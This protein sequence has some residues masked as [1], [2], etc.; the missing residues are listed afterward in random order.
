VKD[1]KYN[2]DTMTIQNMYFCAMVRGK[3]GN[4][5][6]IWISKPGCRSTVY[7][8]YEKGKGKYMVI[9]KRMII[10]LLHMHLTCTK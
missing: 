2:K 3:S 4:A 7:P 6:D 5:D 10:E 1:N 8:Q 9:F